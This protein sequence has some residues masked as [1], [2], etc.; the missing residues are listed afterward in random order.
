MRNVICGYCGLQSEYVD[1]KEIY[2]TS[3]GM[4]YLCRP[5]DAYVRVHKDTDEPLGTLA[6]KTLRELRKM[7]HTA[8]DPIW[9]SGRY[10]GKRRSAYRWLAR[11][12]KVK[13]EAAHIAML[14]AIQCREVWRL[15]EDE[16]LVARHETKVAYQYDNS[17]YI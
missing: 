17:N 6:N 11:K 15:M 10:K 9:Q 4:I 13:E 1:S 16:E 7:A 3:Y 8:F 14:N 12:L 2:G 5:C